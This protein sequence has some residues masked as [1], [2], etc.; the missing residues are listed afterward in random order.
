VKRVLVLLLML[1]VFLMVWAAGCGQKEAA[2][3]DKP[4]AEV[5]AAEKADTT[6]LDSAV[7]EEVIPDSMAAEHD[8]M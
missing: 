6:A 2:Q 3:D 7:V 1:S 4:P 8:S 5:T